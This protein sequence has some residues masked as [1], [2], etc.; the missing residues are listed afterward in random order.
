MNPF[1]VIAIAGQT[2]GYARVSSAGQNVDRQLEGI[3]VD[4]MFI[5]TASARDANRPQLQAAIAYCREGDTLVVHSMDR[6]AR[7]LLDLRQLVESFMNRGVT[8]RFVK[9]NLTF[10]K[11]RDSSIFDELML[12]LLGAFAEFERNLIRERQKEGIALA[13]RQGKYKGGKRHLTEEQ[14]ADINQLAKKGVSK[15][16]LARQFGISRMSVYRYLNGRPV[17]N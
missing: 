3:A 7:N 1:D 14:I 10:S 12:N 2:I 6:F 17:N 13:K 11:N 15:E 16:D 4:K 8:I 5:D 9:E